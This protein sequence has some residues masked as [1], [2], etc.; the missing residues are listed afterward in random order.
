MHRGMPQKERIRETL[1]SLPTLDYLAERIQAGWTLTAL[2]W[3]R[4][5]SVRATAEP[6]PEPHNWVEEIPYGLRV[7]DDCTRLV[8]SPPEIEIVILALDRIVEDAPLS[9]VA[10][11]LNR[12]N[13]RT[14][15][16]QPWTP[17]ALFQL[18]PRMIQMGPRLFTSEQWQ[19]RRARIPK[20]PL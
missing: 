15:D 14:R 4:P 7:S 19:T 20:A 5:A 13:Y 8:E 11:E 9:L 3:E 10:E 6:A 12:K 17:A 1:T 16:G 2:E 18:L